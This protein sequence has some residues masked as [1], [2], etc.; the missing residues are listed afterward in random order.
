MRK[1]HKLLL[2]ALAVVIVA[3]AAMFVVQDRK[4]AERAAE[5][6]SIRLAAESIFQAR[7]DKKNAEWRRHPAPAGRVWSEAR[8]K[9]TLAQVEMQGKRAKVRVQEITT[10]YTTN[11][12]GTD[13]RPD[14]PYVGQYVYIFEPAGDTWT[15]VKD[16]TRQELID[17]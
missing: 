16:V 2:T 1:I 3:G 17:N 12:S 15:L 4:E 10:P 11:N 14:V 9:A 7:A 5:R 6:E 13:V 8:A